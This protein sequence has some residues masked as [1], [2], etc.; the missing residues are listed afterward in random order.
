MKQTLNQ[1]W[2]RL[3][4]SFD[5]KLVG[6]RE[7]EHASLLGDSV[8]RYPHYKVSDRRRKEMSEAVSKLY[9]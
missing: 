8:A 7:F 6:D 3:A 1:A 5:T 4:H 2:E 9:F